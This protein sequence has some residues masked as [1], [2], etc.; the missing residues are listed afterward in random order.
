MPRIKSNNKLFVPI[1]LHICIALKFGFGCFNGFLSTDKSVCATSILA[2]YDLFEVSLNVEKRIFRNL[3]HG[4]SSIKLSSL[5]V[6]VLMEKKAMMIFEISPSFAFVVT[7]AWAI[8]SGTWITKAA[9]PEIRAT[10]SNFTFSVG[11][12]IHNEYGLTYPVIFG[13]S[14]PSGSS[15][16]ITC[17]R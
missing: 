11:P 2:L 5:I 9:L 6:K 16:S 13:L 3:Q 10:V 14:L 8:L 12:T 15:S 17:G 7:N 4:L 1:G